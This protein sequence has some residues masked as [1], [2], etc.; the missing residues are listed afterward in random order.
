MNWRDRRLA[1]ASAR[2]AEARRALKLSGAAMRRG[3][4]REAERH[5]RRGLEL[6]RSAMDWF[7]DTEGFDGAHT[8]LHRVGR[9]VHGRFNCLL[10]YED[11]VYY[12]RCPV[13]LAHARIGLSPKLKVQE[14]L[15]SVCGG[16]H[17]NCPHIVGQTYDGIECFRRITKSELLNVAYVSRPSNPEAR[18]QRVSVSLDA[19]RDTLGDGWTPGMPVGC[20][21]CHDPCAGLV[22]IDDDP[23]SADYDGT[24][25]EG[26]LSAEILEYD[27][28]DAIIER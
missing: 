27:G 13:A 12:Q 2:Q 4:G 16:D 21:V 17:T 19:L 1:T 20:D 15:C 6:L 8:E 14:V 3:R 5:A 22:E 26:G 25:R 7:E 11:G 24:M 23:R 10:E 18:I 9:D 28:E